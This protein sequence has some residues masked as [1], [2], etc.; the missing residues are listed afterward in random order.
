VEFN[1]VGSQSIPE[2]SFNHLSVNNSDGLILSGVNST[3]NGT[4]TFVAGKI[5]TGSNRLILGAAASISGAA[6]GK[7]IFGN[8]RRF[9]SNTSAPSVSLPIGDASNYTPALIAFS[10]T[11]SGSGYLDATTEALAGAPAVASGLSQTKYVNRKWTISNS[12]ITGFTSYSPTLTF[13]NG[14]ILGSANTA[15]LVVRKLDGSTWTAGTNG[16]RTANST[17]AT[18]FTSFSEFYI[19]ETTGA[20][21]FSSQPSNSN[22]CSGVNATFSAATTS[23]PEPSILWQRSTNGTTWTNLT[24]SLDAS[25]IYGGFESSSVLITGTNTG[26]NGY[27]YRAVLTNINGTTPSNSATL[28]VNALPSVSASAGTINCFGDSATVT[29]SATG[30]STPYSGTGSKKVVAGYYNFTVT[31]ANGCASS[32]AGTIS[33]PGP[34]SI[35]GSQSASGCVLNSGTVSVQVAGGTAPYS[36]SP[37]FDNS[38]NCTI[39]VTDANGCVQTSVIPH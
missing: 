13:V 25:A 16:T 3:V 34:L 26:L 37:V 5:T 39:T 28:T 1:G 10:G 18:G 23:S 14:D 36:N 4:L 19:G 17:Q 33:Q 2:F 27:Q 24:A 38:G 32:V 29:V 9:V 11:T 12:G 30:G 35:T 8:L 21:S 6:S 7:Y 15:N 20:P 22:I 31:D